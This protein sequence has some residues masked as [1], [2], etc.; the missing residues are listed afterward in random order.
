MAATGINTAIITSVVAIMGPVTSRIAAEVAALGDMPFSI[1]TCTASTT[2]MASSTTIP[3]AKTSPNNDI[4]L[5][6]KS[7][8]GKNIKA[9]ISETGIANV[10]I[11]VALQSCIKIKTT[12]ITKTRAIIKVSIISSIPAIIGSVASNETSYLRSSGKVSA[13]AS[14]VL[15]TS[16]AKA[17]AFVPGD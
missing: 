9:A 4:E 13:I 14:I 15:I 16:S 2:T 8:I 6:V 1:L 5:T 12:K 7:K 17:T 3:I 10:G 11:R